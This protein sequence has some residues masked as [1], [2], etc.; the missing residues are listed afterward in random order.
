MSEKMRRL[1]QSDAQRCYAV[2]RRAVHEGAGQVYSAEQCAAWAPPHPPDNWAARACAGYAVCATRWG[3]IL[4]FFT[5]GRD[6][7]IDFAYVLPK[8]M[9]TGVAARLYEACE[10]EA[11]RLGLTEMHTEASHLARRFF[12][13]RGWRVI[14]RQTVIRNS[15]GIENFRMEKQ[16]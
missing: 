16:L 1:T 6:G 8:V 3:R 9:G 7:H 2:L 15:V 12:E 14:A 11:R 10:D 5:M 13:K 4:G